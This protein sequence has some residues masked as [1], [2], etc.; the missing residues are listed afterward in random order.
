MTPGRTKLVVTVVVTI[1][2]TKLVVLVI[3]GSNAPDTGVMDMFGLSFIKT[4]AAFSSGD[5]ILANVGS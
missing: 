1:D 5:G 4:L 3:G 2:L